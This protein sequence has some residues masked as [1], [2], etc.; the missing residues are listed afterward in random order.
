M[1]KLE[2]KEEWKIKKE[3]KND[4]KRWERDARVEGA[5]EGEVGKG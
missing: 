5:R 2:E 3:E 1:E 4:G